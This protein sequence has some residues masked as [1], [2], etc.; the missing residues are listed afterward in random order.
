[1][2]IFVWIS[3]ACAAF[4]TFAIVV[5]LN[6]DWTAECAKLAAHRLGD[7][8]PVAFEDIE[9]T[10]A[11]ATCR[12]AVEQDPTP[13]NKTRL[14]RAFVAK[15]SQQNTALDPEAAGLLRAGLD[16]RYLPV[17]G[18]YGHLSEKGIGVEKD[19]PK[20]LKFYDYIYAQ[21]KDL[22]IGYYAGW[23]RVTNNLE[24]PK[25]LAQL[26]TAAAGGL[27]YAYD[28]LG[29]YFETRNGAKAVSYYRKGASAG[30]T[31]YLMKAANVPGL[32]PTQKVAIY[33]EAVKLGVTDAFTPYLNYLVDLNAGTRTQDQRIARVAQSGVGKNHPYSHYLLGWAT[34]YGR[35]VEQDAIE[36]IRL[37]ERGVELGSKNAE[38]FYNKHVLRY[39][40]QLE[41]MPKSDPS[42]C[43]KK[44]IS[45]YDNVNFD[46]HNRC[47]TS[48]N[49]VSCSNKLGLEIITFFTQKDNTSC[50]YA[51]A[52]PGARIDSFYGARDTS[53]L[54]RKLIS[55]TKLNIW[56]CHV[57]LTP[58]ARNGKWYCEFRP[59]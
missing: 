13:V 59:G 51:T 26:E 38:D 45:Q 36:G 42:R 57:P 7:D 58:V 32:T 48:L 16:A 54:G 18:I 19:I 50:T 1:M 41:A 24:V 17:F 49:T 23:L 3:L 47:D 8:P 33:D 40:R 6:R 27:V 2:K 25:G 5:N 55:D 30:E 28:T 44:T 52:R 35:G 4:A 46:F 11:I 56:A 15:A 39:V 20:A 12:K 37:L 10:A 31:G 9:P 14:A 21:S 53:S 29:W 22:D 34:W 43:V